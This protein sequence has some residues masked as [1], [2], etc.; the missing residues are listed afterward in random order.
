MAARIVLKTKGYER[1]VYGC[2]CAFDGSC[3]PGGKHPIG[4]IGMH[5]DRT[6]VPHGLA[7]QS[8]LLARFSAAIDTHTVD[9]DTK[10]NP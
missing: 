10:E 6:P 1:R 3:V 2:A 8:R 9:S 4:N 7:T 5:A